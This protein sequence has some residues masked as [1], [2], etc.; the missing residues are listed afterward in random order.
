MH[1]LEKS[2][3]MHEPMRPIEIGIV[4][5]KQQGEDRN[6]IKPT[7]LIDL[8]VPQGVL[9]HVRIADKDQG[10]QGKNGDRDDG[11]ADLPQVIIPFRKSFLDLSIS[12]RFTKQYIE[13]QKS[14]AGDKH[15]PAANQLQ[16]LRVLIQDNSFE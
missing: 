5:E 11:I 9:G 2:G 12:K 15:I 10:H 14:Q 7:H 8:L 16:D 6:K 1:D 13:E 3:V 4:Y